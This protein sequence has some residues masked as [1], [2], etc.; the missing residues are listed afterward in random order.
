M[1]LIVPDI[2]RD[3]MQLSVILPVGGVLA[4]LVLWVVGW[5]THRFWVVLSLTVL[6]GIVGLQHAAELHTQPL[7]AAVGVAL[8]AGILAMTLVRLL[9]FL[10]GGVAG[11]LLVNTMS[12]G[13]DQPFF[14]FL[15]GA[16]AGL[17]L[18][19]CWMMAMT[20][21][22]GVLLIAYGGLALAGQWTTLDVVAWCEAH[23]QLVNLVATA[24]AM[25]GFAIQFGWDWLIHRKPG[26]GKSAG[27]KSKTGTRDDK[28]D[29][30][31]AGLAA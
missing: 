9:A 3:V 28:K 30:D 18:L 14:A 1:E 16:L 10:A 26:G 7:L 13:W 15:I 5:W 29:M 11:L 12:P 22:A 21:L 24:A 20:S 4:G 8:V 19:R 2:L 25:G 17:F 31:H 23:R 6:G 27:K